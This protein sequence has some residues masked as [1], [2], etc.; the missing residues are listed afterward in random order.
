VDE[1]ENTIRDE[2]A[3]AFGTDDM[4][5]DDDLAWIVARMTADM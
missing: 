1:W 4:E 5:H 2:Y 3:S